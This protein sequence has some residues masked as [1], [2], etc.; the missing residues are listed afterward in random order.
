MK[1]YEPWYIIR[2]YSNS[3]RMSLVSWPLTLSLKVSIFAV[4]NVTNRLDEMLKAAADCNI[5]FKAN[6]YEADN[7]HN[8]FVTR[9]GVPIFEFYAK[10]AEKARRFAKAMAGLRRSASLTTP[11]YTSIK[12]WDAIA[13]RK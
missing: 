9:H 3:T 10:D 4:V 6:P 12:F 8:P 13:D 2:E 7:M 5:S 11:P 1:S